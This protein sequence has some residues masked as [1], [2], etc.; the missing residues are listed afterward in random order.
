MIYDAGQITKGLKS[1]LP[2]VCVHACVLSPCRACHLR[3]KKVLLLSGGV[4]VEEGALF[5]YLFNFMMITFLALYLGGDLQLC[6]PRNGV[7]AV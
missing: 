2:C 4:R 1:C 6:L 3:A 7:A 5:I